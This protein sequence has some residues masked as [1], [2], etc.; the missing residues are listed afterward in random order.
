VPLG[1]PNF[2]L[3]KADAVLIAFQGIAPELVESGKVVGG[4]TLRSASL[5]QW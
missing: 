5:I 2:G 3:D 4:A 1:G